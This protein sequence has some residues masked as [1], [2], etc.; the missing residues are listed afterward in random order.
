[1]QIKDLVGKRFG[2][3]TVIKF[4]GMVKN[5][6]TNVS[7]WECVCDCGNTV[8]V[9][10]HNLVSGQTR[11]CGCLL[12][13]TLYKHGGSKRINGDRLYRVWHGMIDRCSDEHSRSYKNYGAKGIT[14]CREWR[15]SYSSFREWAILNGYDPSAK[16]GKCTV[17]RIDGSKGYSPNN[18]RIVDMIEQNNNKRTNLFLNIGGKTYRPKQAAKEYGVPYS[19]LIRRLSSGWTDEEAVFGKKGGTSGVKTHQ[20]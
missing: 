17:D 3:L 13:E 9:R 14:V 16:R 6:K 4:A 20:I 11:S 7:T 12:A 15:D 5:G 10:R 8:T 18:C 19:T 1:M 2:R